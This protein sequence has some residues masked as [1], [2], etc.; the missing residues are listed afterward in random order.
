MVSTGRARIFLG[1]DRKYLVYLPLDVC[2]DS[3]FPYKLDEGV[4]SAFMKVSFDKEKRTILLE[5]WK[6]A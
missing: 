5:P 1:A 6:E 4:T 3:Q 2:Q